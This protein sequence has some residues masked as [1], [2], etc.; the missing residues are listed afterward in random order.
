MNHNIVLSDI[1]L[2]KLQALLATFKKHKTIDIASD[3]SELYDVIDAQWIDRP[4]Q[5]GID[6]CEKQE[7]AMAKARHDSK[8]HTW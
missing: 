2:M 8:T 7:Q 3:S 1:Q 6:P 5:E 4:N